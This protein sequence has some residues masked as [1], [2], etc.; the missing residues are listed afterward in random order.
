MSHNATERQVDLGHQRPTAMYQAIVKGETCRQC[1]RSGS[2]NVLHQERQ[3]D[4]DSDPSGLRL[5]VERSSAS[6]SVVGISIV[7]S[8]KEGDVKMSRFL[9]V[10]SR[11]IDSFQDLL[12]HLRLYPRPPPVHPNSGGGNSTLQPNQDR[13]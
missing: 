5:N 11:T 4:D 8:E 3:N 12:G 2:V 10:T 6:A 13:H 9:W 1:S 7:A